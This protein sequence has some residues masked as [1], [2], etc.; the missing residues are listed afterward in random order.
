[1]KSLKNI[2]LAIMLLCSVNALSAQIT[3]VDKNDFIHY[4]FKDFNTV[5]KNITAENNNYIKL[6]IDSE[7]NIN[8]TGAQAIAKALKNKNCKLT[9]LD[10]G[11]NKIG[12]SGAKAIA[13]ALPNCKL[14]Y[15]D[16]RSNKIG[17]SGA[18][19]IAEALPNCKLT[20]LDIGANNIDDAGA[21]AIAK[22]LKN[23]TC[24][25]T[26]LDIRSNR[27][28]S[29]G[30]QALADALKD[31]NCKLTF[32]DIEWNN[33]HNVGA[34][35]I[36][37]ALIDPNCKL[38][39]LIIAYNK[40]GDTEVKA[41]ADALKDPNCKITYLDIGGSNIG[42]EGAKALAEAL[43]NPNCKLTSLIIYDNKINTTGAQAIVDAIKDENCKLTDLNI[44]KLNIRWKKLEKT[45]Y[46]TM[47]LCAAN[48]LK[49]MIENDE[50][51]ENNYKKM[52]KNVYDAIYILTNSNNT[53]I[54]EWY[55]SLQNKELPYLDAEYKEELDN[56]GIENS[57]AAVKYIQNKFNN[58]K[59]ELKL[60]LANISEENK[61]FDEF[62]TNQNL[63]NI[64]G[65][66]GPLRQDIDDYGDF[67]E[68]I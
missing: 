61:N 38:I 4:G 30:G 6:T 10:I 67:G 33:I 66:S 59:N 28:G 23:E 11:F 35:C 63:M 54:I 3:L 53:L 2:I 17:P 15:L 12:P 43:K 9:F 65:V 40:I 8:P 37:N 13:E 5:I 19:S 7:E 52:I 39:S 48:N 49:R 58:L 57:D 68:E 34:Q 32:L 55:N 31:P 20:Y 18:K 29:A 21:Q 27:I 14:T 56:H 25:L 46:F 42:D 50:I 36:A 45:I 1:M 16:I 22:A 62:M 24:N 41:L 44:S 64:L 60:E 51:N 26:Y 47:I